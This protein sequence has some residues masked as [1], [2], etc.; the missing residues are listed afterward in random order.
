MTDD[1]LQTADKD[2]QE[3]RAVTGKPRKA[4]VT[5]D[6]YQNFQRHRAGSPPQHGFL[7]S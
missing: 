2:R 5:F 7:I 6:T 3:S 4:A 1:S